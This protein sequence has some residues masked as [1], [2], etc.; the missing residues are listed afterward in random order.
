MWI[1]SGWIRTLKYTPLQYDVRMI[2]AS[3]FTCLFL[4]CKTPETPLPERIVGQWVGSYKGCKERLQF[5]ANHTWVSVSKN[6]HQTGS[7]QLKG[8]VLT[9]LIG[10]D[11]GGESC[12]GERIDEA[13][14][15]VKIEIGEQDGVLT[16]D[17]RYPLTRAKKKVPL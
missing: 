11:D 12:F 4:G 1:R 16:F 6:E 7:W 13:G 5:K 2:V 17:N 15:E 14:K 10:K 3:A 8:I 9:F